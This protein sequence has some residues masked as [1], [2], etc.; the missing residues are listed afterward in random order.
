MNLRVQTF[1]IRLTCRPTVRITFYP[2]DTRNEIFDRESSPTLRKLNC[3]AFLLIESRPLVNKEHRS[4]EMMLS[5]DGTNIE[6]YFI[7]SLS[8]KVETL[9]R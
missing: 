4:L 9:L 8:A 1:T 7:S 3:S 5:F 2:I 6:T